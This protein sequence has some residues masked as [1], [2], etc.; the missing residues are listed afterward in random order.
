MAGAV[1]VGASFTAETVQVAVSP[2]SEPP[3]PSLFVSTANS[4]IPLKLFA[5]VYTS[6]FV[7]DSVVLMANSEAPRIVVFDVPVFKM[8]RAV[9]PPGTSVRN[10]KI[11]AATLLNRTFT[12]N[13][14]VESTS[15]I[16]KPVTPTGVS[17]FVE[18]NGTV[19]TGLS[20]TGLTLSVA[21]VEADWAG[22][23]PLP[24]SLIPIVSVTLEF[25]STPFEI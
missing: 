12:L 14:P 4:V 10:V 8:L 24:L 7:A 5:G 11:P 23:P 25:D 18:I 9:K 2:T 21:V 13:G 15:E 20:F 6:P 22:A 1:I 16:E 19:F 17:S 3:L